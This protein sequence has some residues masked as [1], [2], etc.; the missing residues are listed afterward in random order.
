MNERYAIVNILF[1]LSCRQVR[2]EDPKFDEKLVKFEGE[3]SIVRTYK[4]GILSVQNGQKEEDMWY[5]NSGTDDLWE[6]MDFLGTKIALKD[7]RNFRGGLDIK[8]DF[9]GAH[10]YYTQVQFLLPLSFY[11][12]Y[13]RSVRFNI[14]LLIFAQHRGFEIMF[15]VAPLL[16]FNPND[17]QQLERKRHLGNDVVMV[18]FVDNTEEIDLSVIKSKF[19]HVFCLV[20]KNKDRSADTVHYKFVESRKY[21]LDRQISAERKRKRKRKRKRIFFVQASRKLSSDDVFSLQ[22]YVCVEER[23]VSIHSFSP[24]KLDN[25][26]KPIRK[27]VSVNEM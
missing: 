21:I 25:T 2:V 6:F 3:N 23:S 27:R 24:E 9:T 20:Q 7:W 26:K 1:I 15:H 8:T 18:L 10:S 17:E 13:R 22:C 16:P 12:I 5:R 4:F 19:N 14:F 11:F